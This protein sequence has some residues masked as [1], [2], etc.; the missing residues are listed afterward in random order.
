MEYVM[1]YFFG[2][3]YVIFLRYILCNI[4]TVYIMSYFYGR[5]YVIFY[6]IYYVILLLNKLN[7]CL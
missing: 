6:S 7:H 2:I 5:F 4:F 3:Y 1:L